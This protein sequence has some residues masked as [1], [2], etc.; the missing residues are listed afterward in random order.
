[1]VARLGGDEFAVV[2]LI[3]SDAS[4]E[5]AIVRLREALD[6]RSTELGRQWTART[7]AG[8][9]AWD[10]GDGRDLAEVLAQADQQLYSDKRARKRQN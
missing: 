10:T 4:L 5:G 9:T 1:M 2:S 7:S 8:W 6:K 3:D